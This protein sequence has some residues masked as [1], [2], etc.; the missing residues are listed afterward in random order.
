MRRRLLIFAAISLAGAT[1]IGCIVFARSRTPTGTMYV[2]EYSMRTNAIVARVGL[3]N[4][5]FSVFAYGNHG[6][7]LRVEAVLHGKVTNFICH[8]GIVSDVVFRPGANTGFTVSLPSDTETWRCFFPCH[9]ASMSERVV[10]RMRQSGVW[11]RIYPVSASIARLLPP[12]KS[13]T[14]ELESPAFHIP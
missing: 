2:Y 3:T 1:F 11:N 12:P 8:A 7:D 13:A 9:A 5:G 14:I 4:D 6:V 10:D